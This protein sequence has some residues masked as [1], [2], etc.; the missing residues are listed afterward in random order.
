MTPPAERQ[1]PRIA[2]F[3][4]QN[5]I[6]AETLTLSEIV[7]LR[8]LRSGQTAVQAAQSLGMRLNSVRDRMRLAR[9][10]FGVS[11]TDEMLER[12]DVVA[13]LDEDGAA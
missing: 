9:R 10:R 7:I 6:P 1:R 4:P 5:R 8:R 2:D 12:P 3:P 13:Q 11:S